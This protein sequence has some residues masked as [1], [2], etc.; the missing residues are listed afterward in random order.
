MLTRVAHPAGDTHNMI[1]VVQTQEQLDLQSAIDYVGSLCLGCIDRFQTLRDALPSWG[2]D[3]DEQLAVY[4]DGL[5][6]WMIGNLVWSFETERYFGRAGAQVRAE[7][8]VAL[9]PLRK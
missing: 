9:L 1:V 7:L 5:G 3:I 6:D 2:P 4:V 8:S